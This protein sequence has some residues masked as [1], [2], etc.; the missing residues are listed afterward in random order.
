MVDRFLAQPEGLAGII[1]PSIVIIARIVL[2]ANLARLPVAGRFRFGGKRARSA[3]CP[4]AAI[5]PIVATQRPVS[6]PLSD[7]GDRR[8]VNREG[9]LND[10]NAPAKL[11]ART[12]YLGT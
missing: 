7:G 9:N 3:A 5:H 12:Q 4:Q 1:Q 2:P 8:H 11:V 6:Q 10:D